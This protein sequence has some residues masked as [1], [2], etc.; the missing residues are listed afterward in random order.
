M[1]YRLINASSPADLVGKLNRD[2]GEVVQILQVAGRLSAIVRDSG[3]ISVPAGAVAS[4]VEISVPADARATPRRSGGAR[5]APR[6]ASAKK[7]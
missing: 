6:T 2:A 3:E 4:N 7:P 5:V 1:P